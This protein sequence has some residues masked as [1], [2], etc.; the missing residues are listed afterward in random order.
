MGGPPYDCLTNPLGA[1]RFTFEKAMASG[2]RPS[3][4]DGTDW[5]ALDLFRHFLSEQSALSL[6]PI[7]NPQTIRLVQPNTLVRYRGM[8]QDMLGSEFYVGAY[9]VYLKIFS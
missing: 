4:F 9:K 8:I 6:V 3:A 5:G 2:S 1:V 7:L